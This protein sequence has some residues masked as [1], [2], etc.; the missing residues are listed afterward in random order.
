MSDEVSKSRREILHESLPEEVQR[1]VETMA[2][3]D[4]EWTLENWLVNQAN[5]AMDLVAL[6]LARERMA[7][8]Q[9]L[10]RIDTIARR[11][12]PYNDGE[13]DPL[14]R[15]LFDCFDL[16]VDEAMKGLG[17]RAL[18]EDSTSPVNEE[19]EHPANTFLSM[20]PDDHGDDPLLALT[21]QFMLF[22]VE[23]IL[24]QG[25]PIATTE[26]IF[27]AMEEHGIS[28]DETSEALD[29]LLQTGGLI[30]VDDDCFISTL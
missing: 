8:E 13:I 12:E 15:N 23:S 6:D 29:H 26:E 2:G 20:M 5:M 19:I 4:P 17:R 21:C 14:Q 7:I 3:I 25:A 30:E 16:D 18:A 22:T 28:D 10:H 24:A 1:L 27:D 11:L 9:K